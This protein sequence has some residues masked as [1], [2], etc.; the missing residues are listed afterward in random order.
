MAGKFPVY[1]LWV[2]TKELARVFHKVEDHMA[3]VHMKISL[4][5]RNKE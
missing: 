2:H 5:S 1:K 3:H 4:S